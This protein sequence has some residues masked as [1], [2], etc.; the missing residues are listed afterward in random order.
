MWGMI[1]LRLKNTERC[2]IVHALRLWVKDYGAEMRGNSKEELL[3]L[4]DKID[5]AGEGDEVV[6]VKKDCTNCKHFGGCNRLCLKN[7]GRYPNMW[8]PKNGTIQD[9][10]VVIW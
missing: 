6:A 1:N 2:D 4:A 8:E 7:H 10:F 9:Q 3:A 5:A